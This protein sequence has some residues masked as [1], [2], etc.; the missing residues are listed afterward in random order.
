MRRLQESFQFQHSGFV[1][2]V[3]NKNN[4]ELAKLHSTMI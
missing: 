4:F 2:N 1:F 3:H